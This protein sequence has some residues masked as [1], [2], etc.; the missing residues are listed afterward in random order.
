M[1]TTRKVHPRYF[2][3]H[4]FWTPKIT[5]IKFRKKKR[6]IAT[7]FLLRLPCALKITNVVIMI[8]KSKLQKVMYGRRNVGSARLDCNVSDFK[9]G[10]PGSKLGDNKHYTAGVSGFLQSFQ[11]HVTIAPTSVNHTS[12]PN[13]PTFITNLSPNHS[14]QYNK[15]WQHRIQ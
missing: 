6:N 12:P 11:K 1:V 15:I 2:S 13:P 8:P 5:H 14:T 7:N 10:H 9:S 3:T 4:R